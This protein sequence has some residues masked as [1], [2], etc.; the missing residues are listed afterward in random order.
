MLENSNNNNERRGVC[1]RTSMEGPDLCFDIYAIWEEKGGIKPNL[2]PLEPQNPS[3]YKF[4]V[5]PPQNGFPVAKA[6]RSGAASNE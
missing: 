1:Q 4:Q 5:Y 6:L 2:T 3:L